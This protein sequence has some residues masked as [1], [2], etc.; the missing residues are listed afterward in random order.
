MCTCSNGWRGA[1]CTL[2]PGCGGIAVNK[3][4]N[5]AG[6]MGTCYLDGTL[7]AGKTCQ[8]GCAPGYALEHAPGGLGLS[9]TPGEVPPPL[10][11]P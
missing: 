3:T 11:Y 7:A 1:K 8:L 10:P 4:T 9:S 5:P 2:A 6:T